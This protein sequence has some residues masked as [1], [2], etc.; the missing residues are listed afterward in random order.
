MNATFR[1]N[2]AILSQILEQ[3]AR[4]TGKLLRRSFGSS[5][6]N[7]NPLFIA[8]KMGH[9]DCIEMMLEKEVPIEL[10]TTWEGECVIESMEKKQ[11]L[12]G[13]I[14]KIVDMARKTRRKQLSERLKL[15]GLNRKTLDPI[16]ILIA[17]YI[18]V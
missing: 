3:K 1:N 2:A 8:I 7:S 5:G 6:W 15:H 16:A 18:G 4:D 17:E 14:K 13:E 12:S 10:A 11:Q 9:K